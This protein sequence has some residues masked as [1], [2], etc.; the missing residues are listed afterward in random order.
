MPVVAERAAFIAVPGSQHTSGMARTKLKA[1]RPNDEGGEGTEGTE[2]V[3][4]HKGT[5][6]RT[7]IAGRSGRP[8]PA[9]SDCPDRQGGVPRL[10]KAQRKRAKREEKK[11]IKLEL[12]EARQSL[13][14]LS[15]SLQ[16][17]NLV[18]AM[19]SAK[20]LLW[21]KNCNVVIVARVGM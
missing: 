6:R 9:T 12:E 3:A 1:A 17:S 13:N 21:W 20:Q 5:R 16:I 7:Q 19:R 2:G 8:G 4:R 18:S 11:K 15:C 10:T 14:R